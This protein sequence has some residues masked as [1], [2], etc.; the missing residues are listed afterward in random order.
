MT[1]VDDVWQWKRNSNRR[2]YCG[3]ATLVALDEIA[4]DLCIFFH[5]VTNMSD[6]RPAAGSSMYAVEGRPSGR[7]H[8]NF[9]LPRP[10]CVLT[11]RSASEQKGVL[12][13][14]ISDF[15]PGNVYAF[16]YATDIGDPNDSDYPLVPILD[17]QESNGSTE[18][19]RAPSR[20][21]EVSP[22]DSPEL[23]SAGSAALAVASQLFQS[24]ANA[25]TPAAHS[26]VTASATAASASMAWAS[27]Q[28]A[29]V[30]GSR[31]LMAMRAVADRSGPLMYVPPT[32]IEQPELDSQPLRM[33]AEILLQGRG[34]ARQVGDIPPENFWLRQR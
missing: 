21:S 1:V 13:W 12:K 10:E 15:S 16:V 3:R 26:V 19:S 22:R 17:L 33:V 20:S 2:F 34:A 28:G 9:K 31:A 32:H 25:G 8:I 23:L 6:L 18:T 4:G 11:R 7:F 29:I 14:K 24:V 30:G 5:A 27:G